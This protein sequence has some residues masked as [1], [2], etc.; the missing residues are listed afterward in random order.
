MSEFTYTV[1]TVDVQG[2]PME[3]FLFRPEGEGPFPGIVLAQHIPVGHTGIEND[4][5]TL[6][7]AQRF[8]DNGYAVALHIP[9]V[10]EKRQHGKEK[11]GE[12]R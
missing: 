10:A 6:T 9:L 12:H 5:F 11:G 4:T 2:S 7:T 8:A 3:V 1:E